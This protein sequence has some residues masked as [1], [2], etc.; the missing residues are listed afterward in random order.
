M[1]KS[2]GF[3]PLEAFDKNFE[4]K[5]FICLSAVKPFYNS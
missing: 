3:T 4:L 2:K 5:I 1:N